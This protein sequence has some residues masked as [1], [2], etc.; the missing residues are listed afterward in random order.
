MRVQLTVSHE[1]VA[2]PAAGDIPP[3]LRCARAKIFGDGSLGAETAALRVPYVGKAESG[4]PPNKGQMIFTPEEL[5]SKVM[6]ASLE[7]YTLEV[8]AIG[9]A[10]A[11]A[12]LDAF[13]AELELP[14]ARPLLTHCQVKRR[15]RGLDA[16]PLADCA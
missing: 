1:E 13:E 2:K 15:G 10:A 3:L 4:A 16:T 8:H 7:G 12:V 9:D 11:E 6:L 14:T 5:R